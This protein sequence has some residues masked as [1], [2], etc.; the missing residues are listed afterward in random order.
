MGGWRPPSIQKTLPTARWI[1]DNTSRVFVNM[2]FRLVYHHKKEL[3]AGC[4]PEVL[5]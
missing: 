4:V 1:E 5:K 3:K 2:I